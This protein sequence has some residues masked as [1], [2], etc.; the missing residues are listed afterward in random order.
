MKKKLPPPFRF[1]NIRRRAPRDITL[2]E[3]EAMA[4]P[5][6]LEDDVRRAVADFGLTP[7]EALEEWDI[8]A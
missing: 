2:A 6:G 1:F 7:R 8:I 3:A 5:Y 4:A